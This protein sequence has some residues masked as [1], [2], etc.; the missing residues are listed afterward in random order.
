ME[1]LGRTDGVLAAYNVI[2]PE[3]QQ[4]AGKPLQRIEQ[5]V[6]DTGKPLDLNR[7]PVAPGMPQSVPPQYQS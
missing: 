7:T 6:R 5:S 3:L 2:A 1:T 4:L